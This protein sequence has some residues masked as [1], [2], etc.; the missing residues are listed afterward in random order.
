MVKIFNCLNFTYLIERF[1]ERE[2]DV[3]SMFFLFCFIL[4]MC[5]VGKFIYLVDDCVTFMFR[6]VC[7]YKYVSVFYL[8]N[9]FKLMFVLCLIYIVNV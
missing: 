7:L 8:R 5:I 1:K 4:V 6:K 3:N 2:S 9:K